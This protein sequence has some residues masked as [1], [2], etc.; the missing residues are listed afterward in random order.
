MRR[1][2]AIC[3]LLAA[4]A[5]GASAQELQP[6]NDF[7]SWND[8]QVTAPLTKPLD[9]WFSITG[10]FGKNATRLNDGRLALGFIW[11]TNKALSIQPFYWL[12]YMRNSRAVFQ[13]EHRL[14]LR[15]T[16]KLPVKKFGV[17]VRNTFERR[18]KQPAGS[19]RWRPS[20]TF[21]KELP[22]TLMKGLKFYA[23]E[24]IF[25]DSLQHRFSRN[26]ATVGFT[27][28]LNKQWAVDLYYM[29]QNDGVSLP[30]NL[31]VIGTSWKVRL[32]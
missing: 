8:I 1:S 2:A 22:A 15:I 16:Y 32:K 5:A 11:K 21:E 10:R 6:H 14:N 12:I 27:K 19:W 28:T 13:V 4:F 30:G 26:R 3:A 18:I 31:N 17:S 25:Y 29:R 24:E 23:T 20:I 9:L 7:Q